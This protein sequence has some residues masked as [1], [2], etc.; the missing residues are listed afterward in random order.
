MFAVVSYS[1]VRGQ[2]IVHE[3]MAALG[4]GVEMALER[5]A[6]AGTARLRRNKLQ[7]V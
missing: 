5:A 3:C 4:D 2:G 1:D 6:L 7:N